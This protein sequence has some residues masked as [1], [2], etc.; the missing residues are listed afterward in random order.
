MMHH[1]VARRTEYLLRWFR[2]PPN[3]LGPIPN[4]MGVAIL[5]PLRRRPRT[6]SA[7]CNAGILLRPDF[8]SPKTTAGTIIKKF[9]VK[10]RRPAPYV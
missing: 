10:R 2:W 4:A 5:N 7:R 1:I 8:G 9:V 6:C 3:Q